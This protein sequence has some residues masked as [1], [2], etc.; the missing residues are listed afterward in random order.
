MVFKNIIILSLLFLWCTGF[1]FTAK[2]EIFTQSTTYLRVVNK[3][4]TT[5]WYCYGFGAENECHGYIKYN[6]KGWFKINPSEEQTIPLNPQRDPFD[7]PWPCT[8]IYVDGDVYLY[9]EGADNRTWGGNKEFCIDPRVP[10]N[11]DLNSFGQKVGGCKQGAKFFIKEMTEGRIN[12]INFT[13]N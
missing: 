8:S 7:A 4:N 3:T 6:V 12:I 11:Y 1:K 2:E 10:F 9:A 5:I 13:N